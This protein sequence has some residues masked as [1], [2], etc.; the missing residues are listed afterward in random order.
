MGKLKD[1][2]NKSFKRKGLLGMAKDF[3]N[4][5]IC[6][7]GCKCALLK[8]SLTAQTAGTAAAA[9]PAVDVACKA[10]QVYEKVKQ[11]FIMIV[12]RTKFAN[13]HLFFL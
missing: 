10:Y 7:T 9:A 8:T 12:E 4:K 6:N 3:F 2:I 5:R 11:M 13:L 1:A